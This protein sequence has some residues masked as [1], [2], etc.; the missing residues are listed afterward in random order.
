MLDF[1]PRHPLNPKRFARTYQ[2]IRERLEHDLYEPKPIDPRTLIELG[3]HSE[4]YI[5][6]VQK[7]SKLEIPYLSLY[8]TDTPCFHGIYEWALLYCGGTLLGCDLL[9][10]NKHDV[11]FNVVGGFHHAKYDEDGGF[12]VFNDCALA[13]AYLDKRGKRVAY[14]D[15]DAHAGDGTYMILYD[16]PILKIS[17][18]EDPRNLYPGRGFMFECGEGEGYGYTLNIPLPPYS[19]SADIIEVFDR[20][21]VPVMRI[22]SP[23]ILVVQCGMDGYFKDPITHLSYTC[24][25]YIEIARRL[26]ELQVPLLLCSGGGYSTDVPMLHTVFLAYIV[27]QEGAVGDLI[28]RLKA[29]SYGIGE[30]RTSPRVRRLIER[31]LSEHPLFRMLNLG[32]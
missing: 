10:E 32:E 3:V 29:A 13:I 20:V 4:E 2:L 28:S 15:F 19:T 21:I 9:L 23:E 17:I 16:K 7:C 1:G 30:K 26:R 6:L 14:L 18:H 25:A 8:T 22:Y 27:R 24:V 5:D 12:C 31:I 11:V